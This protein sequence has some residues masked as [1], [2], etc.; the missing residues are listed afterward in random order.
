MQLARVLDVVEGLL[1]AS[2][3]PEI[4]KVERFGAA[5]EP[6]GPSAAQSKSSSIAGIRVTYAS[7]STAMIWGAVWPGEKPLPM[8]EEM[9]P[10]A[11]RASRLPIFVVQL[12]DVARPADFTSWQL[13][14]LPNLGATD[15]TPGGV[16]LV[17]GD[18]TRMLLRCSATGVTVG[19]EPETDPYADYVI[20][21]EVRTSVG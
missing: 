5:T 2:G 1:V 19:A 15:T 3:H 8:P 10:V 13:V 9:P 20:P 14:A 4:V 11:D 6:W 17:C 21:D 12:L 18:G 16:S 7:S